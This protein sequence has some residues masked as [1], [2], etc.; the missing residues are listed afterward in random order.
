VAARLLWGAAGIDSD[1]LFARLGRRSYAPLPGAGGSLFDNAG[2]P[3]LTPVNVLASPNVTH[4]TY[5][6]SP[7][8]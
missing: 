2:R 1:Q 7:A 5:L 3:T 8:I 6:V 4:I